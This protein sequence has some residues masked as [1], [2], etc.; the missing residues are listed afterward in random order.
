[1]KY[2]SSFLTLSIVFL[3]LGC[4]KDAVIQPRDYP[5]I[6]LRQPDASTYNV[7]FI[8]DIKN[9]GT[10]TVLEYGFV[11]SLHSKPTILDSKMILLN[12][13]PMGNF[14]YE[15]VEALMDYRKYYVRAFVKTAHHYVYSNQSEFNYH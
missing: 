14:R 5:F 2:I 11:W 8:A 9:I 10:E 6:I 3:L 1:M 7:E 12:P 13:I 15:K 4:E